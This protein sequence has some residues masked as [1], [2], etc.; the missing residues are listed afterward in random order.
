[1]PVAISAMV[2]RFAGTA[3]VFVGRLRL[4]SA[5]VW[6]GSEADLSC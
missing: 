2:G 3:S 5:P 4:S 1:M 6:D